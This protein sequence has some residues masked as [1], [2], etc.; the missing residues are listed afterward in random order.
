[1][2]TSYLILSSSKDRKEAERFLADSSVQFSDLKFPT[3]IARRNGSVIG[4]MGTIPND[5]AILAG[6]VHVQVNGN[7]SFVLKD[8][9]TAYENVLKAAG[10]TMYNFFIAEDND[11]FLNVFAKLPKLYDRYA[12]EEGRVWFRRRM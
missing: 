2:K 1:M 5:K 8:L 3:V 6:P 9:V 11:K 4:V 10:V 7:P 12:I